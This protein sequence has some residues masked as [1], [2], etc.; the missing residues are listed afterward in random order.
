[1][2]TKKKKR[3]VKPVVKQPVAELE[4]KSETLDNIEKIIE[5]SIDINNYPEFLDE[6]EDKSEEIIVPKFFIR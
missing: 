5:E 1:M 4:T 6:V 3:E 2:S